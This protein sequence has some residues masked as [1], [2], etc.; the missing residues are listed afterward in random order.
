MQGLA[1]YQLNHHGYDPATDTDL[2]YLKY[3]TDVL[4]DPKRSMEFYAGPKLF[5]HAAKHCLL[6][7]C[8][9]AAFSQKAP[10][11]ISAQ[12]RMRRKLTPWKWHRRFLRED[13]K[14]PGDAPWLWLRRPTAPYRP[15]T[16][17]PVFHRRTN[18]F[19]YIHIPHISMSIDPPDYNDPVV[20]HR[21]NS[22]KY[23]LALVYLNNFLPRAGQLDELVHMCQRLTL[24]SRSQD[25]L[26]ESA[27]ARS[28]MKK[29]IA[30]WA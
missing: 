27:R 23:H 14:G 21:I 3:L 11:R 10:P 28:N 19:I 2:V 1:A 4:H 20:M 29:Y 17:T 8:N 24:A 7:L 12:H 13:I 6:Y 15:I 5:A 25:F 16:R 26:R 9:H 18:D 30:Q 22:E